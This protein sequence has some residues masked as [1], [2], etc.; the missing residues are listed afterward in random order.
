M[1]RPQAR[2][3]I[4]SPAA[5]HDIRDILLWSLDNFGAAAAARYRALLIQALRDIETNPTRPG[6][7][8]R[9]EL[10]EGARTYHLAFSR[11]S[12]QG[13]PLKAPRHFIL[14]RLGTAGLAVARILHDSRDLARHVPADYRAE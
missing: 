3:V 2:R 5:R 1:A 11:G 12:V 13:K 14:Y 7:Q 8:P 9:P 4:L 10:A 6:S